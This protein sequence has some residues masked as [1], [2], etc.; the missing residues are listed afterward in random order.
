M[1]VISKKTPISL[2]LVLAIVGFAT[3][4]AVAY[5][6]NTGNIADNTDDIADNAEEISNVR[7]T[8][9]SI[10]GKIDTIIQYHGI[11]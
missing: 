1:D 2:N 8:V 10:E 7:S 5:A 6:A 4:M 11:E 3:L 9:D